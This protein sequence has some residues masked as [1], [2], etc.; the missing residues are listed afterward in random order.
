[1]WVQ[2][3]SPGPVTLSGI[4]LFARQVQSSRKRSYS[5]MRKD[6]FQQ[7]INERI[8]SSMIHAPLFYRGI[9]MWHSITPHTDKLR[10]HP[11][12]AH[13]ST[14][15]MAEPTHGVASA[16]RSY[17]E[18]SDSGPTQWCISGGAGD[19]HVAVACFVM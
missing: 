19:L 12:P 3:V 15:D 6:G 1:M 13:H 18:R 16:T 9:V 14:H 11:L 17:G 4:R 2:G 5:M 10:I 7:V 8:P